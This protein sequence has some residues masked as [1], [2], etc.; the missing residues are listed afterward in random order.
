MPASASSFLPERFHVELI[1]QLRP[2]WYAI[3]ALAGDPAK[4]EVQIRAI[5]AVE[6]LDIMNDVTRDG[7]SFTLGGSAVEKALRYGVTNWKGVFDKDGEEVPYSLAL[8]KNQFPS[9]AVKEIAWQVI[10]R[11]MLEDGKRKNSLSQSVS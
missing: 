10:L 5:D 1:E 6:R 9:E 11:G 7:D 3:D 2:A 8:L 4:P